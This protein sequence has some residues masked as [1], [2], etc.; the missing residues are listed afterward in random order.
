MMNKKIYA[1]AIVMLG[2]SGFSHAA[3]ECKFDS[4]DTLQIMSLG[5]QPVIT[6]LPVGTVT[7]PVQIS[8]T[9]ILETTPALK[10]H[11][12]VGNDG[13]NVYQMTNSAMLEGN[14]DGKATF[15]TNIA[16]IVYTLAFYPDGNAVTA[17]F[18]FNPN[19]FYLTG[20]THDNEGAVDG[21]TWHVRMEFWQ[22]NGFTGV[23][24]DEDFLTASTGPIGQIILGNP[25]G[26]TTEDHPRPLVNMS[27]MS[28]S[29]PLNRPT[30]AMRAPSNVDLGDWFAADVENG[31]T[32]AV[33]FKI[34]GTC[35]NT[36][37]VWTTLTSAYTT[38]DKGYFTNSLQGSGVTAAGGVG[39]LL[40]MPGN[41]SHIK[42]DS[43]KLLLAHSDSFGP[44][45][46]MIDKTFTAQLVKVGTDPVTVGS[47]GNNITFQI[48]YD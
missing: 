21:K 10:S 29:I 38:T 23:P 22:T 37:E 27:E 5:V 18:P 15:R 43:Y 45:T 2:I 48:T 35:I 47:F 30:C 26:T 25:D 41:T 12:A 36:T 33:E 14:I 7:T 13:E 31:N 24:A 1:L 9:I 28:F 20:D 39:V 16:G 46:H 34:S 11:C 4:N 19:G 44:E 42:A 8:S 40:T 6:P 17:W 32:T 3:M